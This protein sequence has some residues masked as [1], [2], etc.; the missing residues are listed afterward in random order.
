MDK[1]IAFYLVAESY[2]R[3]RIGQHI[4]VYARRQVLGRTAS[5]TRA[6]WSAAGEQGLKP[7]TVVHMFGPD[8]E[9]EKIVHMDQQ[10]GTTAVFA[11]YRA[12]QGA[13]DELELYLER[14]V[15]PSGETIVLFRPLCDADGNALTDANG[16]LLVV[17]A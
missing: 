13:N 11:V 15:G 8:Y 1:S 14:K 5:I 12:Y 16:R 17:E 2:T 7:E 10:D 3:D 6:E 9:G 4:P